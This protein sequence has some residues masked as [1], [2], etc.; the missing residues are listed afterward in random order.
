MVK[1]SALMFNIEDK[2]SRFLDSQSSA[3]PAVLPS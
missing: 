3:V 2:R 1:L